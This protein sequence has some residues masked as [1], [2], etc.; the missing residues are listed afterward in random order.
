MPNYWL[1]RTNPSPISGR[2]LVLSSNRLS[3]SDRTPNRGL[4][5]VGVNSVRTDDVLQMA[6]WCR[7]MPNYRLSQTNL[8]PISGW[9]LIS[10]SNG[11]RLCSYFPPDWVHLGPRHEI[12]M[13]TKHGHRSLWSCFR[14]SITSTLYWWW[15]AAVIIWLHMSEGFNARVGRDTS[16]QVYIWT[17]SWQRNRLRTL[18]LAIYCQVQARYQLI[19][20]YDKWVVV[21]HYLPSPLSY[22]FM[23]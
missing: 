11:P 23:C 15:S 10:F 16:V 4:L 22:L 20:R 9:Q 3:H 17:D 2:K 13:S 8:S 14:V 12:H 5:I 21:E 18:L 6:T 7:L 19:H 1:T